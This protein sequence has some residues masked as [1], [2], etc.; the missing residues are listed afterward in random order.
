MLI[1]FLFVVLILSLLSTIEPTNSEKS[2]S[3]ISEKYDQISINLTMCLTLQA[4][5]R[6]MLRYGEGLP[7]NTQYLL[8]SSW[9]MLQYSIQVP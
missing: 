6:I 1:V 7:S 4:N 9:I 3:R 5:C 8:E 2:C